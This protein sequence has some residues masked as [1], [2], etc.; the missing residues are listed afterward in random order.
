MR[1]DEDEEQRFA[2]LETALNFKRDEYI[3][4][5]FTGDVDPNNDADWNRY[6][7]DMNAVGLQEF[8]E[9]QKTVYER[10][11]K[12]IEEEEAE[13]AAAEGDAAPAAASEAPAAE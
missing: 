9:L 4:R 10:T 8:I 6:I 3:Q 2:D 13:M 7:S 5:F 12:A 11:K 1:Y